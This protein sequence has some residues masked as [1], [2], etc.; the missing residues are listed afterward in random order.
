MLAA[1][2][3]GRQIALHRQSYHKND[4]IVNRD[5]YRAILIRQSFDIENILLHN[6]NT[7]DFN[8]LDIDLGVYDI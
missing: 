8:P 4:M 7:V 2:Y 1:Y 5:H 3:E 6:P